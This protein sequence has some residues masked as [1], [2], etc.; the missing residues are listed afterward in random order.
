MKH[1]T[2]FLIFILSSFL[3]FST[4]DIY[5]AP[6]KNDTVKEA[7]ATSGKEI[8]YMSYK[9]RI[10]NFHHISY[11]YNS[12]FYCIYPSFSYLYI[13]P[14]FSYLGWYRNYY[15]WNSHFN[16]YFWSY[17]NYH[18]NYTAVA[19][20]NYHYGYRNAIGSTVGRTKGIKN[21]DDYNERTER[22]KSEYQIQTRKISDYNRP[23]R[24][25]TKSNKIENRE[26]RRVIYSTPDYRNPVHELNRSKDIRQ[27]RSVQKRNPQQQSDMK[28]YFHR[29]TNI[30][31]TPNRQSTINR[32]T[33]HSTRSTNNS[34]TRSSKST[35]NKRKDN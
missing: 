3:L 2:L 31:S 30:R 16:W 8:Y 18:W 19:N 9:N 15:N 27:Q 21:L 24:R 1:L 11:R 13:Y 20:I 17:Y 23:E 29:N 6:E 10:K 5:Y 34:S 25:E 14:N 35:S 28:R 26:R 4:D 22:K 32:S 33:Q 12:N 7:E